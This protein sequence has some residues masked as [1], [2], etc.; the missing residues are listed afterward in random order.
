MSN[1]RNFQYSL[2]R[3]FFE[4]KALSSIIFLIEHFS[5]VKIFLV[6]LISK[7]FLA[8]P[9]DVVFRGR[10]SVFLRKKMIIPIKK[11]NGFSN[12][13]ISFK[14][15]N[16]YTN[17]TSFLKIHVT[18]CFHN[19]LFWSWC[20]KV[21]LFVPISERTKVSLRDW[22]LRVR[23]LSICLYYLHITVYIWGNIS[24]IFVIFHRFSN[25]SYLKGHRRSFLLSYRTNL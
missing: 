25:W 17:I 5:W 19:N 18:C 8:F 22:I 11:K 1:F 23:M 24:G 20:S 7:L 6:W 10:S 2:W 9:Y 15:K 12:G 21:E 13:T 4:S 16:L 14:F 3:L